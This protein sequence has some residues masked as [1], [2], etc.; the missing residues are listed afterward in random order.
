MRLLY[1]TVYRKL[2]FH[3]YFLVASGCPLH[4][5]YGFA[6]QRTTWHAHVLIR[7]VFLF[8]HNL[9]VGFIL[10][11]F[12]FLQVNLVLCVIVLFLLRSSFFSDFCCCYS[13]GNTLPDA[14]EFLPGGGFKSAVYLRPVTG[15]WKGDCV[16]AN[17]VQ[18][19]KRSLWQCIEREAVLRLFHSPSPSGRSHMVLLWWNL[20]DKTW[21]WYSCNLS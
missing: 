5:V 18:V 15:V 8:F 7:R 2:H 11:P 16:W 20:C 6:P 10:V 17:V 3:N 4:M 13:P 19:Q 1:N 12:P 14:S 9:F 21:L